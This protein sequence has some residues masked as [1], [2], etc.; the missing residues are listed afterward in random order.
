MIAYVSQGSVRP[1]VVLVVFV[2]SEPRSAAGPKIGFLLARFH[3][4]G[5]RFVVQPVFSI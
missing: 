2:F 4:M 3:R 1:K 5:R